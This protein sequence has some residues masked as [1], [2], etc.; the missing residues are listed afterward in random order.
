M[1]E[2]S[3]LL[4]IYISPHQIDWVAAEVDAEGLAALLGTLWLY[5]HTPHIRPPLLDAP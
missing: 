2:F 4:Y 5:T 1:A 3:Q